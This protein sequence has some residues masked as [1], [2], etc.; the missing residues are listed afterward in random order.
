MSFSL[1]RC[2][3]LCTSE[4][5]CWGR[6]SFWWVNRSENNQSA[7]WAFNTIDISLLPFKSNHVFLLSQNHHVST[8]LL[9]DQ[10]VYVKWCL[11][12]PPSSGTIPSW[13]YKE[14]CFHC[15][16]ANISLLSESPP[17]GSEW[18]KF[19]LCLSLS[20]SLSQINTENLS[21][22]FFYIMVSLYLPITNVKDYL[23]WE[24]LCD[25]DLWDIP[26]RTVL[27]MHVSIWQGRSNL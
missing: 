15:T 25:V 1:K 4:W 22:F 20:V 10:W 16:S 21:Y 23:C 17:G 6:N 2:C 3:Q 9:E 27:P 26:K 18:R 24:F 5:S 14:K 13:S 7:K 19:S 11:R 12:W 8:C